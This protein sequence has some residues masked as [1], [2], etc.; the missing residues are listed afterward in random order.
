MNVVDSCGWLEYFA[1]GANASFFAPAIEDI[2]TLLVPA[3]VVFEVTRRLLSL[4]GESAAEVALQYLQQGASVE[5]DAEA[6][7]AA[8]RTSVQHRLA[9]G[10]AL[11]Y[12]AARARGAT[13]WTQDAAFQGLP[14]VKF[15]A[16]P[17][18]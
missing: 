6:V 8:A 4:K 2:D 7:F 9:M 10:D 5:L 16:K 3:I 17:K 12:H 13:L 1:D 15:K 11:I 18:A 14:A